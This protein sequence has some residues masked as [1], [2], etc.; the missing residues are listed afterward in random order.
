MR[1]VQK[2]WFFFSCQSLLYLMIY[3]YKMLSSIISQPSSVYCVRVL[4]HHGTVSSSKKSSQKLVNNGYTSMYIAVSEVLATANKNGSQIICYAAHGNWLFIMYY[5]L[6]SIDHA[7]S[8]KN[9]KDFGNR[10]IKYLSSYLGTYSML[11]YIYCT[12]RNI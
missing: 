6:K 8:I 4:M 1:C 12:N 11:N 9:L 5:K 7:I 2:I 3:R 10:S